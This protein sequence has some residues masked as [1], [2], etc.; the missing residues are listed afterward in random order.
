MG[1]K[2]GRGSTAEV[3]LTMAAVLCHW[4]SKTLA[5][6][7]ARLPN[8][9]LPRDQYGD[10]LLTGEADILKSPINGKF[11]LYMNDWGGCE[12]IDCCD[13]PSGCESCCLWK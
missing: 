13:S 9:H 11:Y 5:E 1:W 12:G 2:E 6:R 4:T 3:I 8:T 10:L 7:V